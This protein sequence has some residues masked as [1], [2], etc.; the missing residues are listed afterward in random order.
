MNGGGEEVLRLP[1][2]LDL[3][4][5]EDFLGTVH[6]HLQASPALRLDAS[7][8]ETLTLPCIQ[9]ILA[10]IATQRVSVFGASEAFAS[11]FRDL[12]LDWRTNGEAD[13]AI[14]AAPQ[15]CVEPAPEPAVELAPAPAPE[16]TAEPAP[17]LVPESAV[18]LPP[19]PTHDVERQLMAEPAALPLPG[20]GPMPIQ[21]ESADPVAPADA[22][23]SIEQSS[24]QSD[25]TDGAVTAKRI[26]TIDDSK[27]MR[28][29]LMLT[30]A[31][32]GFE[33]LQAVDGQDGLDVLGQQRVDVVITDINMPIMD[34]YGVIRNLRKNPVH[35][36]TPILVLTTESD[37]EKKVIAREAGATGWMVKPFDPDRLI[38]T[39]RKVAP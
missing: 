13:D 39:I 36:T 18:E 6:Q 35:K 9:I 23:Q 2:V 25:E 27:T 37:A 30:L 33:V 14:D 7:A 21:A 20:A 26:L 29:M 1:A 28:D 22:N 8:V 15:A 11:A 12:A 16:P 19:A 24:S 38:A 17:A 10:G 3:A 31:E 5:S 32:A 4:A 34:G